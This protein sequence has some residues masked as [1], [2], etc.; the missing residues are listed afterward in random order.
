[1][2]PAIHLTEASLLRYASAETFQHGR[3][4]Y[5]QNTV[6]TPVLYGTRL[7][8]EVKEGTSKPAWVCCLFQHDG[9]IIATCTCQNVWAGWCKHIVAACLVL[10]HQ[11]ENV[12]QRP[13][14]EQMLE[15]FS[16][17]AL[18]ALMVKL[19]G[20]TP[21]LAEAIDKETVARQPMLPQPSSIATSPTP[22]PHPKVDSKAIRRQ[23]RSAIH[24]LNRMRSS[25]AY[26]HVSE[27]VGEVED[28]AQQ[29]LAVLASGNGYGALAVLEA[30]TDEY[31]DE[32][33]NLDDSD[34]YAG[35]LFGQLGQLW[36][37]VLLSTELS[38]K[39]RKHWAD[40]LS[41]WQRR[42]EDYGVDDA[43]TL[44]I[45]AAIHGWGDRITQPIGTT[46]EGEI[47]W[48]EETPW[49]AKDLAHIQLR[50]LERQGR[51]QEYLALAQETGQTS[52]YLTMLVRLD[53]AQQ[54]VEYGRTSLATAEEALVLARALCE[55]GER[56]ESLQIAEQG[57]TLEGRK[58]ELAGWLRDQAEAM[59]RHELALVAAEQAFHAQINLE[60]YRH[61]ARLAGA[62]WGIRKMAL[63]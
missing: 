43:F 32:W 40:R 55:H 20:T 29:A 33:I 9:S 57:L 27:V 58:A 30:V 61:A 23:V 63:L 6:V 22:A 15:T 7:L 11:P 16:R 26:W 56:E 41:T 19:A 42:V 25:E 1:M 35:E 13:A 4:C 34:G 2:M 28:I 44:A 17:D 12:K 49:Y 31:A 60:H 39:E 52:A 53:R 59:E 18:Q 48:D 37:E 14:L 5:Q 51:F 62:Q 8:A 24:S 10:L 36:A 46:D 38:R 21:Y 50:I 45:G 3:N 54:A 47:V